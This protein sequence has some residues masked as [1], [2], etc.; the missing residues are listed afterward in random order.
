[1]A[2]ASSSKQFINFAKT[3]CSFEGSTFV[4]DPRYE[5]RSRVGQGAQGIICSAIDRKTPQQQEVR[6]ATEIAPPL[7]GPPTP[8]RAARP[9]PPLARRRMM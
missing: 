3:V 6:S 8:A 2:T 9:R 1:M 5:I 4:V 7:A